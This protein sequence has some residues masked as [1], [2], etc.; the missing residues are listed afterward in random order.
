MLGDQCSHLKVITPSPRWK[1]TVVNLDDSETGF[2]VLLM[3]LQI[4]QVSYQQLSETNLR[5]PSQQ[6]GYTIV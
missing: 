3:C 5:V 6:L 1:N 2:V 4:E